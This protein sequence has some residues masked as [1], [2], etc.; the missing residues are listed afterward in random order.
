LPFSL[1]PFSLLS[2]VCLFVVEGRG[3]DELE[4]LC[5]GDG[6]VQWDVFYRELRRTNLAAASD[7]EWVL[8]IMLGAHTNG[9]RLH[10]RK[11]CAVAS[12]FGSLV[13]DAGL[14]AA[15]RFY[16]EKVAGRPNKHLDKSIGYPC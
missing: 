2:L 12:F 7:Q 8:K 6:N 4:A 13:T 5:D 11:L 10:F 14:Q 1:L 9:T 15:L 3:M 16:R